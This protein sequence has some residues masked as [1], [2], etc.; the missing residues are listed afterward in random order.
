MIMIMIMIYKN[1]TYVHWDAMIW[2]FFMDQTE[3]IWM[4]NLNVEH[5]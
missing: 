4:P 3:R 2:T 1:P 5:I